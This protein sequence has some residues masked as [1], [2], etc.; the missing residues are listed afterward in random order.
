MRKRVAIIGAG[1][2]GLAAARAL[3]ERAT[4]TLFEKSRGPGGRMATRRHDLS[5]TVFEFDHGAQFFTARSAEF[6]AFLAPLI[7]RG[8]LGCWHA[9]FAE[10]ERN[11][12][13]RSWQWDASPAHYVGI[14]GMNAVGKALAEGLDLRLQTEV[15]KVEGQAAQWCVLD[16]RG[17]E[18]GIFDW[19]ICAAPAAQTAALIPVSS[20]LRANASIEMLPCYALMLGFSKPLDLPWQAARVL[21]ADLSWISVNSSKPGR[22]QGTCLVAHSTNAWAAQNIETPPGNIQRHLLNELAD[23]LGMGEMAA[24]HAVVHRWR[25]ANMHRR[26][27]EPA[28]VDARQ[29]LAIC[30]DWL[31]HG[32][33]EAAFQS[34]LKMSARLLPLLDA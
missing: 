34:A 24:A 5:D 9:K 25:Y 31:M 29:Q 21:G 13:R 33:V 30:G 12:L 28:L 23:I 16:K 22:R 6:R 1:L 18:L 10:L 11:K 14:P 15:G 2:S 7:E 27:G 26:A 3:Q 20:P 4:V 19:V 8:I 32:R 17:D